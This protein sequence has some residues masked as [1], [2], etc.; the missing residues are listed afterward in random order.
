TLNE[1]PKGAVS[2]EGTIGSL[3]QELTFHFS[4][5]SETSI[6]RWLGCVL[7]CQI[8]E[9]GIVDTIKKLRSYYEF[10]SDITDY[11][12]AESE[13][14]KSIGVISSASESPNLVIVD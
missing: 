10:Y 13:S 1:N 14:T 12:V 4:G 2:V 9:I 8:P 6:L 3:Q 11:Q 7:V 5:D